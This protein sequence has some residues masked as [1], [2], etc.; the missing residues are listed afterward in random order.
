MKEAYDQLAPSLK[1]LLPAKSIDSTAREVQFVRRLR[2]V[3]ASL[4]VWAVVL[5]RF[6]AGVPG[7]SQARQWYARLGGKKL[8]PRPF[9]MRFKAASVVALFQRAFESAVRPWRERPARV[10]HPLRRWFPDIVLWDSTMVRLADALRR[11]F[12]G[13]GKVGVAAL[14]V[15]LAISVFGLLPISAQLVAGNRNDMKLFP[16]LSLLRRGTLLLFDKGFV[17]YE[18]LG[19]IARAG[20]HYVCPMR[21]NGNP[22]IVAVNEGPLWVRRALRSHPSGIPLHKLLPKSKLIGRVWDLEVLLPVAQKA[23]TRTPTRTRLVIVPGPGHCQRPYLTTLDAASWTPAALAEMYRLR[24]QIELVFKELKQHLNLE[25]VPSKDPYAVQAFA[26]AS[27]IAL[28]VSRIVAA[29]IQPL[30]T[31]AGLAR[32]YRPSLVSRALRTCAIAL[33]HVLTAAQPH[34]LMARLLA[35]ELSVQ[36][37]SRETARC[38]S[39]QRL[40]TLAP[41]A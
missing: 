23:K 33:A 27:L 38:D 26:W 32:E 36:A 10:R 37:R 22:I 19:Q 18:R 12:K 15:A 28:A 40:L 17:V 20:L 29:W 7:F 31:L 1:K 8:C 3:K 11:R 24:W 25:S 21:L 5:S 13:T 9:Q 39:F 16:M 14:K 4:F 34:A 2:N 30:A 41:A 35:D 6:G